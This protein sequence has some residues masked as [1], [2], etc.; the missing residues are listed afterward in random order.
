MKA[1]RTYIAG[2]GTTGVLL[3]AAVAL[4][5]FVG[6]LVGFDRWPGGNLGERVE[7]VEVRPGEEAIGLA[8]ALPTAVPAPAAAGVIPVTIAAPAAPGA[9]PGN[10]GA[11]AVLG[12]RDQGSAPTG[13]APSAP[14]PAPGVPPVN[15]AA[16]AIEPP[17]PEAARNLV[18]DTTQRATGE[19]GAAVGAVSPEAGALIGGIGGGLA[20]QLRQAPVSRPGG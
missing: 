9:A 7:R 6:A 12:D 13:P 8:D 3:A 4:L 5:F 16:P 15:P 18:A 20:D 14:G 2:L 1:S 10:G 17:D 11:P 19:L